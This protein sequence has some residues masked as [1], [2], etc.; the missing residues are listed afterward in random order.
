VTDLDAA[1]PAG[2]SM[3]SMQGSRMYCC[4][5]STA[6]PG[7]RAWGVSGKRARG[8]RVGLLVERG[9]VS[10]YVNGARLGPGPM[11]T[12]LPQRVRS[13]HGPA[14]PPAP[15]ASAAATHTC[16]RD[17]KQARMQT[18]GTAAHRLLTRP[19]SE[20]ELAM[21]CSGSTLALLL[22]TRCRFPLSPSFPFSLTL[23]SLPPVL[24]RPI[25]TDLPRV[26]VVAACDCVHTQANTDTHRP[27]LR[28]QG[29]CL[30]PWTLSAAMSAVP[31]APCRSA[32]CPFLS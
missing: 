5:N 2:Q 3:H 24:A 27:S 30:Q 29:Q 1:P 20:A 4:Y 11:A 23:P 31:A 26:A 12:D 9:E 16:A 18:Q 25:A 28:A 10:V 14:C 6:Y 15:R 21:Q 8:D 17:R 7:G 32:C 19:Q 22:H 13:A